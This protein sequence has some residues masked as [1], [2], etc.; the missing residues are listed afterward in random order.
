VP[1]TTPDAPIASAAA[2]CEPRA[3]AHAAADQVR[4]VE[5]AFRPRRVD[6][7]ADHVEARMPAAFGAD[8]RHG[9]DADRCRLHR[10]AHRRH[11]V[12]DL[13][14]GGLE[15]RHEFLRVAPG[16]FDELHAFIDDEFE[17]VAR[18]LARYELRQHRNVDAER[19]A[20]AEI[21]AAADFRPQRMRLG[22]ACR[23]DEADDAGVRRRRDE[24]R[25]G[26]PH[27]PARDDGQARAE[28]FGDW[29]GKTA[30]AHEEFRDKGGVRRRRRSS[31]G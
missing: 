19:T 27:Q 4:N 22:K 23:R 28:E 2:S 14:A 26:E 12:Q 21:A 10:V 5:L 16:G 6:E 17:H 7:R 29:I 15:E 30:L 25:I 13:H 18:L 9:I 20:V 1:I 24:V 8:D 11:L 31:I 3:A